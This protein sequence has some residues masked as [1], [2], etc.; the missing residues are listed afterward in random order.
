MKITKHAFEQMEKRGFTTDMLRFLLKH[1]KITKL[2][3]SNPSRYLKVGFVDGN[4]WTIVVDKD[5]FTLVTVR[6]AHASEIEGD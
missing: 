4:W 5:L 3:K 2:S 1:S 6:R